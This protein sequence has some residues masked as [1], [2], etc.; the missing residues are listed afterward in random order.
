[1]PA[2]GQFAPCASGVCLTQPDVSCTLVLQGTY[3]PS[4]AGEQQQLTTEAAG[5]FTV[6]APVLAV[7]TFASSGA[8]VCVDAVSGSPLAF[9]YSLSL[10]PLA[11]AT[12]TAIAL[13]TVPARS[14]PALVAKYGSMQE[15]LPQELWTEV[16]G[17]FGHDD[18]QVSCR[19]S[20]RHRTGTF[21]IIGENPWTLLRTSTS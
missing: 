19:S 2:P 14:D 13:L 8:G 16:Y 4:V 20:A 12:V 21:N 18:A 6:T 10:P 11:N 3:K 17:M 5:R 15:V 1:V 7:Y 9:P